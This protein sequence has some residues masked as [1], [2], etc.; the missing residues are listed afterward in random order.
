M[1]CTQSYINVF[2]Y[3]QACAKACLNVCRP[4]CEGY[5]QH[6]IVVS[7]DKGTSPMVKD[8]SLEGRE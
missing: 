5:V 1:P 6:K 4:V 3:A 2:S 7:D 8:V